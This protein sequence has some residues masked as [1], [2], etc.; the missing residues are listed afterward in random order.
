MTV[1]ASWGH[2]LQRER[3]GQHQAGSGRP[4]QLDRACC[5]AGDLDASNVTDFRAHRHS[6]IQ[7]RSNHDIINKTVTIVLVKMKPKSQQ[8]TQ[9]WVFKAHFPLSVLVW[10]RPSS[11]RAVSLY[12][13]SLLSLSPGSVTSSGLG[14]A[15]ELVTA[16]QS[17]A[18]AREPG[19]AGPGGRT[20]S[21]SVRGKM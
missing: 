21:H 3:E 16:P 8:A 19:R 17:H 18:A 4:W 1:G 6:E 20:R 7:T 13:S 11:P 10:C 15:P 12:L 5:W 14:R 9:R 2:H